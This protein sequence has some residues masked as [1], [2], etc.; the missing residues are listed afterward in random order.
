M[1]NPWKNIKRAFKRF[2]G[3]VGGETG[4]TISFL[5]GGFLKM[6]IIVFHWN[7]IASFWWV[8]S[9]W[10]ALEI[11]QALWQWMLQ[12]AQSNLPTADREIALNTSF[13][14]HCSDPVRSISAVNSEKIR[15]E[16]KGCLFL[17]F[18]E[19]TIYKLLISIPQRSTNTHQTEPFCSS[20][21]TVSLYK[22]CSWNRISLSA[23][24]HLRA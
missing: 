22:L 6:R 21:T 24:F 15:A 11:V 13:T 16:R 5:P 23:D 3:M 17:L 14:M 1:L 12:A 8:G 7:W 18:F 19:R 10:L 9:W 2:W 20:T 4:A